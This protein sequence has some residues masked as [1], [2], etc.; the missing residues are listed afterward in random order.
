MKDSVSKQ[1]QLLGLPVVS[2]SFH[3][4]EGMDYIKNHAKTAN[5]ARKEHHVS[6]TY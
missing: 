6:A 3:P 5:L 4:L 2:S 1:Q